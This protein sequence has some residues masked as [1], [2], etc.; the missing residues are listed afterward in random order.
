M[1]FIYTNTWII[2]CKVE[3]FSI[4]SCYITNFPGGPEVQFR[5]ESDNQA[6]L[7]DTAAPQEK[8]DDSII[9]SEHTENVSD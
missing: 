9:S 1:S 6:A 3:K 8:Q 2:Y 5:K 4:C 7:I